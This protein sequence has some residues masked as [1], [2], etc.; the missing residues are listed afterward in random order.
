M[1]WTN[2]FPSKEVTTVFEENGKKESLIFELLILFLTLNFLW[3][4]IQTSAAVI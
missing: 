4:Y 2:H 1:K 3:Y